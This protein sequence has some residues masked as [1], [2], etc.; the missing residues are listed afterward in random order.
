MKCSWA[1]RAYTPL[2][3][4]DGRSI[5]RILSIQ[6][7]SACSR[8]VSA[9]GPLCLHSHLSFCPQC[10]HH[11]TLHSPA[12]VQWA[13]GG[14]LYVESVTM[15][16]LHVCSERATRAGENLAT[17]TFTF[18]T[19]ANSG[20]SVVHLSEFLQCWRQDYQIR[21]WTNVPIWTLSSSLKTDSTLFPVSLNNTIILPTTHIKISTLSLT[22][23]PSLST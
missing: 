18:S 23:C 8:P 2:Y 9:S 13:L 12:A 19:G 3:S 11:S 17:G 14:A 10:C 5:T 22:P 7:E 4:H 20:W 6:S 21:H 15:Y 16:C 1:E